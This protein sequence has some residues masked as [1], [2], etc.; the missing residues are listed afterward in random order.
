M[1]RW[2]IYGLTAL[3]LAASVGYVERYRIRE[4]WRSRRAT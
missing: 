3:V 4:W 2:A 1:R